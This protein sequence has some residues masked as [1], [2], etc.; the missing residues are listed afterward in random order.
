[1]GDYI[2]KIEGFESYETIVLNKEI[3]NQ[4]NECEFIEKSDT[5]NEITLKNVFFSNDYRVPNVCRYRL[6]K[7]DTKEY[8]LLPNE[9][10]NVYLS[11]YN[12]IRIDND[13]IAKNTYPTI[14]LILESPHKDEYDYLPK[15]TPK[16]PAQGVT[17]TQICEKFEKII[18]NHIDELKLKES[19]YR[20][21]I[22]NPVPYQTSLY[23]FHNKG[24]IDNI[25]D[26]VWKDLWNENN[27]H[28]KKEFESIIQKIDPT[29]IINACTSKLSE[30]VKIELLTS[31]YEKFTKCKINHPSSWVHHSV[32]K[33]K[34]NKI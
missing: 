5:D 31:K 3:A 13:Y 14:I 18:N 26:K 32:D 30:F 12:D 16:A 10:K 29:L 4:F 15:L 7:T 19:E 20:I 8:N 6:I 27:T 11:A 28:L 23:Y 2:L 33:L 17:G 34:I 22:I 1:M 21:F 25:R 9:T 24:M